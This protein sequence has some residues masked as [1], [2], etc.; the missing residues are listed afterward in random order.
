VIVVDTNVI[1]YLFL[2]SDKS[3]LAEIALRKDSDWV[4]PLLWRS[5]LRN[6]LVLYMR[7]EL[8]ALDEAQR[9]MSAA[10]DLMRGREYAATSA[11]ILRLAAT[12]GCSAYDCEFVAV[13]ED[14]QVNLVT[15]DNKILKSFP[16]IATSLPAYCSA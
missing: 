10:A 13:A 5:E 11:H 7:K 3:E 14:L 2:T 1:A 15:V 9:I 8:L 6:V 12:S 16:L 4:A